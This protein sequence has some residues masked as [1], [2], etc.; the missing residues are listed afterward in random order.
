MTYKN[1]FSKQSAYY[2][3]F[4]PEYP[5]DLFEYLASLSREKELAWDCA[6][7]SGQAAVGLSRYFDKVTATDASSRQI[8]NA[9]KAQ[10]IEYR[11]ARAEDSGL[12]AC[13]VDLIT[14]AQALHWF[15]LDSFFR[16]AERVLKP[17]G[18]LA[19]WT[20]ALMKVSPDVDAV[21]E[22]FHSEIVG[23]Y[24]PPERV[25]VEE[26][27]EGIKLPFEILQPHEFRMSAQWDCENFC[28]YLKSWS[29]VQRFQSANHSNPLDLIQDDLNNAWGEVSCKIEITW[30]L[31]LKIGRKP[32]GE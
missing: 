24:W 31:T 18:I 17:G 11:L 8:A 7:G 20:Y 10:N 28:G 26:R 12:T 6:T 23:Q 4:R 22:K 19:V 29:A 15:D 1:H 32:G 5:D 14:V 13:S 30:P 25:M 3:R 16:E 2:A 9:K 21:I 27:Y